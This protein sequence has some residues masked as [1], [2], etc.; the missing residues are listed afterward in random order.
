M[1]LT[2][3][4]TDPIEIPASLWGRPETRAAL[5]SHDTQRL[6]HLVRQYAGASQTRLAIACGLTQGKVSAIMSGN[7][8][9]TAFEVFERIADG[10]Q[11]PP[12]ARLAFGLAPAALDAD[13]PPDCPPWDR[14]PAGLAISDA[15]APMVE[16][17]GPAE[18][19]DPVRRRTFARLAGASLAGAFLAGTPASGRAL[20]RVEELAAMLAADHGRPADPLVAD[21]PSLAKAVTDAKI[22]YQACRYSEVVDRLPRLLPDL[23]A[24][25]ESLDGEARLRAHGLAADAYHVA[26]SVLLK[27][28]DHGLAW[29][30]A[31]RSMR[32][33]ASS[34]DPLI[35][36]SA[37]RII[38]HALTAGRHYAAAT[39]TA[40][41][42]AE[43]L[44]AEVRQPTPQYLSV[45]GSLLLRGAIAAAH[46]EDRGGSTTLLEEAA[47]AGLRL[48]GD[49]NHR[50]TAFGPVN[51]LLHRV[52]VAVRL[53]DAGAAIDYARKVDLGK[54]PITERKA[55]F[56][57]D[58]AQAFTQW[59]KHEKAYQ[60]LRAADQLAPQEIR[61]RPAVGRMAS[62]LLATAP[63]TMQ[64]H[65]REF[66][67]QLAAPA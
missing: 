46:A 20:A 30:A 11:M 8:R 32:A 41:R 44:A 40:G 16:S 59:G 2:E 39:M 19:E 55:A 13:S 65:I 23:Q 24:A 50:W 61:S 45:Y 29:L 35:I 27:L 12:G 10:L 21:L 4:I 6:F 63:P 7:H 17:P 3:R 34:E 33:A 47:Q 36:G 60:A 53:G 66:A 56:F 52:N 9:V 38:T 15:V 51:V 42:F 22:A 54:L 58:T 62:D 67:Q 28:D 31:D 64:P 43:R 49:D 1:W 37:A 25:C 48:V 14:P 26:A 18:S 57:I 5:R